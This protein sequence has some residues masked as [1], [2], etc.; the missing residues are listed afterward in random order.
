MIEEEINDLINRM[1][2]FG[3]EF[4]SEDGDGIRFKSIA[5]S[6]VELYADDWDKVSAFIVNNDETDCIS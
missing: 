1:T 4:V 3:W 5:S 6:G 2:D